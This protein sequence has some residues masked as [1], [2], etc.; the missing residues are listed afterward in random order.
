M[1]DLAE[2]LL[3]GRTSFNDQCHESVEMSVSADSDVPT[4]KNLG[5]LPPGVATFADNRRRIDFVLVF[6]DEADEG[7]IETREYYHTSLRKAGL[8]VEEVNPEVEGEGDDGTNFVL[9]HA[10]FDFL[11]KRTEQMAWKMPL[12]DIE[13]YESASATNSCYRHFETPLDTHRARPVYY[14]APFRKDRLDVYLNHDKPDKFFTS[15]QRSRL[16]YDM[17]QS[18]QF[19]DKKSDIGIDRLLESEVY[20]AAY[21]LHEGSPEPEPVEPGGDEQPETLRQEL[22][23]YWARWGAFYKFQPLDHIRE[24][25]GEQIAF[26]FAWLGMYTV[27]LIPAS[28][29]GLI[30]LIYGLATMFNDPV[31]NQTCGDNN[32]QL[33]PSCS[34]CDT[35]FLNKTCLYARL[36]RLFDNELTIP[37][38]ILM[39]FWATFF[40]EYWKRTTAKLAHR[41]D[42]MGIEEE[43]ER[44]RPQYCIAAS[45]YPQQ[46]NPITGTAEPHFPTSNRTPRY[47]TGWSIISIMFMLLL[48]FVVGVVV[49]RTIVVVLLTK[50]KLGGAA[51][52]VTSATSSII[53]L[54]IILIMSKVYAKLANVLTDWEMHRTESD[55]E[56]NLTLKMYLFEFVNYYSAVIYIAFFKGRFSGYP[57][58]YNL[59]FGYRQEECAAGGCFYE[60][61]QQLLIILLGKQIFS[62]FME[63]VTPRI[64]LFIENWRRKRKYGELVEHETDQWSN[65]YHN[66]EEYGGLFS[67]YLEM[68]IQFGFVTVF[69]AAMPLAPL[70]ALLNNII[71]IRLDAIQFV[72]D[73]RR[74]VAMKADGIGIWQNILEFVVKLAVVANAFLIAFTSDMLPQIFYM[75]HYNHHHD[76]QSGLDDYVDYTLA[77]GYQPHACPSINST[78]NLSETCRYRGY[79]T[80][81]GD[82]TEWYYQ[83]LVIRLAF[84]VLFEHIVF[85]IAGLIDL[86]IPD[87]PRQLYLKI[88]REEYLS[89]QALVEAEAEEDEMRD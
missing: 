40:L 56:F 39:S 46:P 81:S 50:A 30:V 79:R 32:T 21:P 44:P 6:T 38:A 48:I 24:Y 87:I 13:E 2:A 57:C 23:Q 19:S 22:K 68:I 74:P 8:H 61:A 18:A 77:E 51:S 83:L 76:G 31:V 62:N 55:Y 65:D 60:L 3:Q 49:Y 45:D 33:C 25:F 54:I 5:E 63:F 41:W 82:H 35:T 20:T 16:V 84:V 85:V 11:L 36:T 47:F 17:L 80:F 58:H 70:L 67:E 28:I 10:P 53:N 66:C 26:Y 14:T 86:I 7:T 71:E 29:F 64:K 15:A 12:N 75:Y 69:V 1:T 78:G 34:T 42:V 37:F 73:M 88:K 9:L 4:R 43:A 27:W 52:V 72:V 89:K 59:L